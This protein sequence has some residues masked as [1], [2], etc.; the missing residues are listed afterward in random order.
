[1]SV[2]CISIS[3]KQRNQVIVLDRDL[4]NCVDI[5]ISTAKR[6]TSVRVKRSQ[7]G[8][9]IES[10]ERERAK[11]NETMVSRRN[12]SRGRKKTARNSLNT[13]EPNVG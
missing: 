2:Q 10:I 1:M 9:V 11:R 6:L 3:K 4:P 7:L 13:Q 5:I 8:N 12:S